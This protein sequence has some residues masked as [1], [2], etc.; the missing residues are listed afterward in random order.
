MDGHWGLLFHKHRWCKDDR[1]LT[2]SPQQK[3]KQNKGHPTWKMPAFSGPGLSWLRCF[4][5]AVS[6]GFLRLLP[7]G[8]DPGL[9]EREIS[10]GGGSA[11]WQL[12]CLGVSQGGS[13][14]SSPAEVHGTEAVPW[15]VLGNPLPGLACLGSRVQ[16]RD[17][18]A[19]SCSERGDFY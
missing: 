9:Q 4:P 6:V 17:P 15:T 19:V 14:R 5:K 13:R 8:Q 11:P 1:D 7:P 3:P 10:Q 18:Q 2:H 12:A 16:L